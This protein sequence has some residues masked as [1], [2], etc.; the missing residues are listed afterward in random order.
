[1]CCAQLQEGNRARAV[2]RRELTNGLAADKT[3][4]SSYCYDVTLNALQL[5][6]RECICEPPYI[7]REDTVGDLDKW[8]MPI[9]LALMLVR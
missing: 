6:S 8:A 4:L 3:G 7:M 9:A 5:P 1:M 2:T